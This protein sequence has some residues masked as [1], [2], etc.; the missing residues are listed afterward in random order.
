M[1]GE[2][3]LLFSVTHG[4][5]LFVA[6]RF[7]FQVYRFQCIY[8]KISQMEGLLCTLVILMSLCQQAA[9]VE[10]E[11]VRFPR[12]FEAFVPNSASFEVEIDRSPLDTNIFCI[13]VIFETFL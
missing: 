2:F 4:I 6:K 5:Y 9:A 1:V 10:R 7:A 12:E 11:P 13:F 8:Q 3:G